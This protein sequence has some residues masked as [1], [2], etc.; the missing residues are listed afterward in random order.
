MAYWF[1]D[2]EKNEPRVFGSLPVLCQHIGYDKKQ[3]KSLTYVFSQKK[4]KEFENDKF[5]IAKV[6]FERGGS[7]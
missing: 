7:N 3:E 4:E 1:L 5:R 2:K 6:L